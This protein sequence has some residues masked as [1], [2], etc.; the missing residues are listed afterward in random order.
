MI[1]VIY[2]KYVTSTQG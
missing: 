2:E 1:E